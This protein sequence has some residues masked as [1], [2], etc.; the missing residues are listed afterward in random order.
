MKRYI[1]TGTPGSGKTSI[2]HELKRQGYSI[3]EEAATDVITREHLL[4]QSDP[5][6]QSD[7]ID[8]IIHL[9]KQR[10]IAASS[11]P[12]ACQLYDRSPICTFALSRHLGYPP[13]VCLLEEMQRIEHERIYQREVFFIENLG[14]C[15]PTEARKITFEDSL[16][17][18]KIH[19]DTYTSLGY[20]L[21]EIAPKPLA[22]RVQCIS[23]WMRQTLDK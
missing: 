16:L 13:S 18:E 10:Q 4:G 3:V 9:Q 6:M 22:E 5:W 12:D 19:R 17:F 23:E 15:Q 14:F 1:L 8:K 7:F 11:Y 20:E 2:L 21:I